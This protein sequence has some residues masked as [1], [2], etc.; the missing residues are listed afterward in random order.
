MDN[1][2]IWVETSDF[3]VFANDLHTIKNRE[4]IIIHL[5][6]MAAER[7]FKLTLPYGY[8]IKLIK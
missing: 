4:E 1:V 6:A 8:K 3:L 7:G 2:E 5:R